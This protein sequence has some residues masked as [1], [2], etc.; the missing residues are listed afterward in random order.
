MKRTQK[1]YNSKVNVVLVVD[2]QTWRS[3]ISFYSRIHMSRLQNF[4]Q[5]V[6]SLVLER[7]QKRDLAFV[8]TPPPL[9]KRKKK[10][11]RETFYESPTLIVFRYA[12]NYFCF[13]SD[14]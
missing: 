13:V 7:D 12:F 8:Q 3:C 2:K 4:D 1:V 9:K 11:G 6:T 14:S 10:S 5:S